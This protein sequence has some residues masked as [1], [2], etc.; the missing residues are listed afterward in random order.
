[1]SSPVGPAPVSRGGLLPSVDWELLSF[2]V[3]RDARARFGG[4]PGLEDLVQDALVL[5]LEQ[6]ERI[7][8]PRAWV[9][10]TVWRLAANRRRSSTAIRWDP[11]EETRVPAVAADPG[12]RLDLASVARQLAPVERRLLGSLVMGRSHR[13]IADQLGIGWK[14][15]GIRVQRLRCKLGPIASDATVRP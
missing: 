7:E 1:M 5:L 11:S 14:S 2:Q 6:R 4:A 8:N 9:A 15:V 3:R 13:E 12:L 10:S